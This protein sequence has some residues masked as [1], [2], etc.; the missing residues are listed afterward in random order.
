MNCHFPYQ[1]NPHKFCT[2]LRRNKLTSLMQFV[3]LN[4]TRMKR[5]I[6]SIIFHIFA[7]FLVSQTFS[8]IK[9][10]GGLQFIALAGLALSVLNF[11]LRPIIKLIAFPLQILTFG[12]FSIFIN[13]GMLYLLT[14]LLPQIRIVPFILQSISFKTFHTGTYSLNLVESFIFIAFVIS[15]V[16][17]ILSWVTRE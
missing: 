5:L 6:A 1:I 16:V 12:L 7:I 14:R 9:I 13:A 10:T 15:C 11:I 3:T 8:G 4:Q 17:T 2:K